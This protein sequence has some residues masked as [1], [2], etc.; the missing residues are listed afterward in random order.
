MKCY[1]VKIKKPLFSLCSQWAER[2]K[3]NWCTKL[4]ASAF[5]ALS[6][7]FL[8]ELG[9]GFCHRTAIVTKAAASLPRYPFRGAVSTETCGLAQ[10]W[11]HHSAGTS[12]RKAGRSG[13]AAPPSTGWPLEKAHMALA[14]GCLLHRQIFTGSSSWWSQRVVSIRFP[15]QSDLLHKCWPVFHPLTFDCALWN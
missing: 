8:W 15:P 10:I 11:L 13:L 14:Q 9:V 7:C 6:A 12:V 3:E 1:V 5:P 2:V 4:P